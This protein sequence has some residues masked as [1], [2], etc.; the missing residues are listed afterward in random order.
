MTILLYRSNEDLKGPDYSNRYQSSKN[1]E[2]HLWLSLSVKRV[3]NLT[4]NIIY[5]YTYMYIYIILYIFIYYIY[6]IYIINVYILYIFCIYILYLY[7]IYIYIY[8]C[9]FILFTFMYRKGLMKHLGPFSRWLFE[10]MYLG[11]CE[12]T[13]FNGTVIFAFLHFLSVVYSSLSCGRRSS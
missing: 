5:I 12:V 9:V 8:V 13:F 11:S 1:H 6:Y 7:Y 4:N 3:L 2:T 10:F